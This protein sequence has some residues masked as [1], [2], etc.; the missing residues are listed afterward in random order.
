MTRDKII[1]KMQAD[2]E[3]TLFERAVHI[4]EAIASMECALA[5]KSPADLT[6]DY[7]LRLSV[8]RLLEII[9]EASQYIPQE[10]REKESAVAWDRLIEI[11]N[12]LYYAYYQVSTEGLWD[13]AGNDLPPLKAFVERV[14]RDQPK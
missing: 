3:S 9:S 4:L 5:N 14:I 10:I 1:T 8:E 11:G 7:L 2:A 6:A 12:W 13:I